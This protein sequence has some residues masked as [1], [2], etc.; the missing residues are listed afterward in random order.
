MSDV[1][2]QMN[3]VPKEHSKPSAWKNAWRNVKT[4]ILSTMMFLG[5]NNNNIKAQVALDNTEGNIYEAMV[6]ANGSDARTT[7]WPNNINDLNSQAQWSLVWPFF[8][9]STTPIWFTSSATTYST[10]S[11]ETIGNTTINFNPSTIIENTQT[12]K[13]NSLN[14]EF[15]CVQK[16]AKADTNNDGKNDTHYTGREILVCRNMPIWAIVG[17]RTPSVNNDINSWTLLVN[18]TQWK[19]RDWQTR[20]EINYTPSGSS[21]PWINTW[22]DPTTEVEKI[23]SET[24]FK[25]Y[26]N[27]VSN[28]LYIKK[29]LNLSEKLDKIVIVNMMGQ[30][31]YE[32]E[33][34]DNWNNL[35]DHVIN[36]DN[37][38]I[39]LYAVKI[40]WDNNT[41][42][43]FVK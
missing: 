31:V 43:K 34:N 10:K 23:E 35:E 22:T 42:L 3:N 6:F 24:N 40:N 17:F 12:M 38:P 9:G 18:Q 5:I 27:P 33:I 29:P 11:P 26:P 36:V 15:V 13:S 30:T 4:A 7:V 25:I 21:S 8:P 14:A 19:I 37:L 28:K 32:E 20:N 41:N 2:N 16:T 1:T 39:G